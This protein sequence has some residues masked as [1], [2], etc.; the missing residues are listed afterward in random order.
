MIPA[1]A[2]GEEGRESELREA[3]MAESLSSRDRWRVVLCRPEIPEN[4]GFVART[5]RC[6]GLGPLRVVDAA[7][8]VTAPSLRATARL[9][10]GEAADIR[11]YP[12]L[13]SAVSDCP[14]ALGFTRRR[15][16]P[17]E[18]LHALPELAALWSAAVSEGESATLPSGV[19]GIP[20]LH[21]WAGTALVFGPE[22]S[23]LTAED[24]PHITH[25][26]SIPYPD[27]VLSLNLSHAVAIALYALTG[28][29]VGAGGM[30]ES[31]EKGPANLGDASGSLQAW[32]A[33]W[34]RTGAL[35]RGGK[36]EARVQ[37]LEK[38]WKRLQPSARELEFLSGMLRDL[39]RG[40][41]DFHDGRIGKSTVKGL[42]QE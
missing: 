13:A 8:K 16:R 22:S 40:S 32:L 28:I 38:L 23:G 14:Q 2:A 42:S 20:P 36:R 26:L 24:A 30:S 17:D 34:E 15:R 3:G 6:Y 9:A 1:F 5:C 31:G 41:M 25:W 4:I 11:T 35:D 37:S 19:G 29:D 18:P 21:P 39:A 12:D 10:P 33:A 27:P 7:E